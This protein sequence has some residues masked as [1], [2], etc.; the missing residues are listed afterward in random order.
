[1]ATIKDVAKMAN[2]STA[3]VSRIINNKPGANIETEKRVRDA[4]NLLNYEPNNIARSL[5][6][7]TSNLIALIIPNLN[8]PYFSDLV[9]IIEKETN[10]HGYK[11]YLCN[12]NDNEDN[13]AYF[14]K[15]IID[16]Y[17][18]TVI[19]NSLAIT[20]KD[21]KYLEK[22]D[23]NVITIDRTNVDNQPNTISVDHFRGSYIAT[24]HLIKNCECEN[25]L[26][27]SGEITEKSSASRFKGYQS[28]M[29]EYLLSHQVQLLEGNFTY[30]SGFDLAYNTLNQKKNDV[31][32]IVCAND[33]M[34]IGAISACH[35][36][37]IEIPNQIQIIGYDNCVLSQYSTPSLTTINQLDSKIGEI[38]MNS[39]KENKTIQF[40]YTPEIVIRDS[41]KA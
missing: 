41:T 40:E 6:N 38:I 35:K 12:S 2:V 16:N 13:I 4:I 1:M 31:H 21:I 25:I 19:I 7:K 29:Q 27:M 15:H 34:A 30:K 8:N 14:L 37:G 26:F 5:S 3:T 10:K 20:E 18:Q 32:G 23:I 11:L 39:I 17:I 36:L 9:N 33:A 28:A 24:E 22:H